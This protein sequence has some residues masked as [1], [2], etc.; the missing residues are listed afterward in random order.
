MEKDGL[1]YPSA[2][3]K[4]QKIEYTDSN[5]E[6]YNGSVTKN[7]TYLD[8]RKDKVIEYPFEGWGNPKEYSSLNRVNYDPVFWAKFLRE[9]V[10]N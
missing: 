3:S 6:Q 4:I 8:V 9:F 5:G 2:Y 7:S 10:D 1:N